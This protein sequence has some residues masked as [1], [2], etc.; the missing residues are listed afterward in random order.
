MTKK[1]MEVFQAFGQG[2]MSGTNSWKSVVADNIVFTGPVD[3]V[4]GLEAF[5]KLNE[6]FMPL[7][8]GND[9]KQ[10]VEVGNFVITQTVMDVATPKGNIIKLDMSEWYEII[11]GKIQNIKVYYNAEDYV[12]EFG[13]A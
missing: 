9:M 3:Q 5:A 10:V 2:L 12:K 4:T 1:P 13:L 6:D 11:D 8:R 7:V